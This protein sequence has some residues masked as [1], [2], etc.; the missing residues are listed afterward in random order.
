M[1]Q[2]ARRTTSPRT[3]T[4]ARARSAT[5]TRSRHGSNNIILGGFGDD[6]ITL[7]CGTAVVLGDNGIVAARAR[8]V[9]F[10]TLA[11]VYLVETTDTSRPTARATRSSRTA[12]RT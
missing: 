11:D 10:G 9:G 6:Q 5:P 2:A 8:H 4:G 12:A 3:S 7:G 1:N